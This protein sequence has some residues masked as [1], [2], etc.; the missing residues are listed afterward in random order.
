MGKVSIRRIEVTVQLPSAAIHLTPRPPSPV[1]GAS[2][3]EGLGV[4]WIGYKEAEQ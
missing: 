3:G 2:A 4:K 1:S